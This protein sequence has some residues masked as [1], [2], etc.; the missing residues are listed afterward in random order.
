MAVDAS[1]AVDGR[2]TGDVF[3]FSDA[4]DLGRQLAGLPAVARC[5]TRRWFRF[6]LGRQEDDGDEAEIAAAFD[7][8]RASGLDLRTLIV[9]VASSAPFLAR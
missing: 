1:A 7:A 5:M 3:R 4:I 9:A 8:F 6:A 2:L